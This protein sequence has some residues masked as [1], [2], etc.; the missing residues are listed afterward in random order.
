[1]AILEAAVF[2]RFGDASPSFDALAG[3]R[4]VS[5]DLKVDP[6]PLPTLSRDK[7]WAD[8]F[9]GG[10]FQLGLSERWLLSLRGDIGGFGVGSDLTWN[11]TALLGYRLSKRTTLAIGYR[12]LD[13][14]YA[15]G[16]FEFDAQFSGPYLGLSFRF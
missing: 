2:Y 12:H 1:M 15:N 11:V 8:P 10:R 14:D 5:I 4:Y 6:G 13:I 9:I 7:D 3:V 16:N